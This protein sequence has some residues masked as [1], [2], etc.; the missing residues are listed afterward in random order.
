MGGIVAFLECYFDES[1]SH[2]GSPVL[3]VAGYIFEKEQCK[4]LDLG[5][6]QVLE[7]YRLPFFH[8]TS[9]A[10]HQ[11]PFDHLSLDDCIEAQKAMIG[12]I[13]QH[14]LLGLAMVVNE[15]DY[16]V[17]FGES[18]PAGTPYSFCCW[19]ILAGIRAWINR[20]NF[21]GEIAY[22]YEAGHDSMGEA[23]ALMNRIF[24]E[25][26]LREGYRYAGHGF[27]DKKKV[28]PVQT[29]DILAWHWATQM[30]R[31][32]NNNHKMRADFRALAEKPQ[33]ELF[34]ANRKTLGGVIAYHRSLQGL[35]VDGITG[36]F[37]R[38]WF[39]SSFD[40]QQSQVI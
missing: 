24:K 17:M 7:R 30:K 25:P 2:G 34:I 26:H 16:K 22:F 8:M 1:G 6:K 28:R 40:G 31:W 39:W 18:S 21:Q 20:T 3:C 14:A 10:H 35:P 33:H 4:A 36:T 23:N 5:W 11:Y 13:N 19:Q 9:C 15:H 12:L 37:G 32:L 27:V 38:Y 29:A